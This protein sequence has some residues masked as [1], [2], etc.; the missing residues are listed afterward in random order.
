MRMIS[1]FLMMATAALLIVPSVNYIM[2]MAGLQAQTLPIP[3]GVIF[4]PFTVSFVMAT[5]RSLCRLV[6]DVIAF[7]SGDYAQSYGK[8][9]VAQ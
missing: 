1:N 2:S 9:E 4:V 8:K 7:R 6:L 5:A 3:R